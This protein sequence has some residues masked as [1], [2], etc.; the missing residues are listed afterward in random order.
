MQFGF[1]K[2]DKGFSPIDFTSGWNLGFDP[3]MGGPKNYPMHWL[4]SWTDAELEGV[5][6]YLGTAT[7]TKDFT[8]KENILSK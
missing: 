4:T 3:G 5:R 8:L 7:Y 6:N 1:Y 2:A